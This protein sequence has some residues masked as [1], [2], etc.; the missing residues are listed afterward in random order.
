M[1][2]FKSYTQGIKR[3]TSEGRLVWL[4]WLFNALFSGMIY[5][6]FSG[7]LNRVL[8]RSAEAEKFLKTFDMNT[9]FELLTYNG[10][11]LKTIISFAFL[12]FVVY[13]ITSVF[14]KGGLLF[15][16]AH[17]RDKRKKS[18]LAPLFFGGGGKFFGRFFRLLIYSLLLWI[19][20][21]LI[22][23]I[24]NM[25]LNPLTKGGTNESLM[26]YL[27]LIRVAFALFLVFLVKMITDYARIKIVVEDSRRVF[28]SLFQAAGF[29]F[30]KIGA[31]LAVYYL[32]VLTAAVLFALYTLLQKSVKTH[33]LLPIL[34]A[35]AI[36]QIFILSRG[37]VMV[38][39]QAAQMKLLTAAIQ[40][41]PNVQPETGPEAETEFPSDM[42]PEPIP[43]ADE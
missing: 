21:A 12:L 10:E 24:L 4:L 23:L 3:A 33:S 25:V 11:A 41:E 22:I 31:T 20:L 37:W 5:L 36:G 30:R 18:R 13:I 39:L 14:L 15:T 32:F 35:L 7:Y 40:R 19:G 43:T 6:Q 1:N 28:R 8:S 2:I 38:G 26:F 17:P 29:V 34:I 27:A 42:P 9:F 16:L